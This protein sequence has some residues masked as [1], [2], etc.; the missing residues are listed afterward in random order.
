MQ[1]LSPQFINQKIG[2]NLR[3]WRQIKGMSQYDLS[4]T[5]GI[6][7]QQIQKYETGSNRIAA[8]RLWQCAQTLEL[9]IQSF[10][11]ELDS[12]AF[13]ADNE[14]AAQQTGHYTCMLAHLH[15]LNNPRITQ[16]LTA[17]LRQLGG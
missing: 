4:Q 15:Q 5:L 1:P 10:Y 17:L 13:T 8:S 12:A 11:A 16:S 6:S 3:I 7:F 14:K 2:N 9:P